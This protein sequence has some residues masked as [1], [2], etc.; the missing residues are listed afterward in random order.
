MPSRRLITTAALGAMLL[1]PG[2]LS[3]QSIDVSLPGFDIDLPG[4]SID[5]DIPGAPDVSADAGGGTAAQFNESD[6]DFVSRIA[7]ETASGI[8]EALITTAAGVVETLEGLIALVPDPD[9]IESTMDDL[10]NIVILCT[11]GGT[12]EPPADPPPEPEG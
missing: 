11:T 9:E 7:D 1:F 10:A 4:I 12:C 6:F 2:A 5:V 8:S 3:A